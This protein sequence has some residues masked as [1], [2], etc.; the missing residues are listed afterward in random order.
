MISYLNHNSRSKNMISMGEKSDHVISLCSQASFGFF[1]GFF[2]SDS[3]LVGG[4]D[5]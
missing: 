4:I 2:F 5:A 3:G 1:C